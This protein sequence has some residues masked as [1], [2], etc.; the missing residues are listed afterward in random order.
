MTTL[1]ITRGLPGS[2]KST[3]ADAWVAEDPVN[4]AQVNR[5][6]LRQMMHNGVWIGGHSGTERVVVTARDAAIKAM[7]R[8]GVDVVCSDTNLPQRVAR[9]LRRVAAQ[10]GAE[11]AVHDLTNV[12]LDTCLER[13]AD[14]ANP[15]GED[16]IRGMHSR[17][18]AGKSYP[19]PFP[20]PPA[21]KE[22]TAL[23]YAPK[24][25]APKAIMVDIDGTVALMN[26]RGPF[27]WAKVGE[28]KPNDPVVSVVQK[29]WG[30]GHQVVFLSGRDGSCR[31]ETSAWLSE[32]VLDLRHPDVHLYM[33]PAGDNR[34]DS[35]VKLELFDQHVRDAFDVRFVLDDR[36]QVVK[37]WRKIG[38][39]VFQVAEGDF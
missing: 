1:T 10:A 21:D 31:D 5:D 18:L 30:S 35:I 17:Y 20:E 16:V 2:G 26:G 39:T 36:D 11:F 4:R 25:G 23:P 33:R 22:S 27:E 14:R 15:V 38:L 37:A 29:Y 32:H 3:Y 19:L 28:D 6:H 24:A 7:L 9:D 34:K 13:D 12:P 8:A